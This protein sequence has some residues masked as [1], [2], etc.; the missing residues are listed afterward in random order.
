MKIALMFLALWAGALQ[1]QTPKAES[2][3]FAPLAFLVGTWSA[4]AQGSTGASAAGSYSFNLEM[5]NHLLTRHSSTGDCKGPSDYNCSH[6]DLLYVY[7]EGRVLKA[8]FF[9]NEGHVIHYDVSVPEP[10]TAVFLS[11]ASVPG[12]QYRLIYVLKDGVMSG[13]FQMRQPGHTEWK[14]YLEW[15]G[16]KK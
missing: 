5:G 1:A 11:D 9:D 13:K 7:A 8:I 10:D 6:G 16:V 14:S 12:P 15:S 2:G 4:Q 3:P